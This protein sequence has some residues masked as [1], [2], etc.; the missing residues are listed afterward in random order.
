MEPRLVSAQSP[1][2]AE[3]QE[4]GLA[5]NQLSH[6]NAVC[7]VC[8]LEGNKNLSGKHQLHPQAPH[9]HSHCPSSIKGIRGAVHRAQDQQPEARAPEKH[10]DLEPGTAFTSRQ[11]S[12]LRIPG[13]WLCGARL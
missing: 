8:L 6:G 3:K 10:S 7:A 12:W 13:A 2:K 11:A 9:L 4:S 5:Q 1:A